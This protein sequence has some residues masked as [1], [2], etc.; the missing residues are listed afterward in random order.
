MEGSISSTHQIHTTILGAAG[1]AQPA[2][3]AA[4][5]ISNLLGSAPSS[6]GRAPPVPHRG[7]YVKQVP[8]PLRAPG[9]APVTK[10]PDVP[11]GEQGRE[12]RT[13]RARAESRGGG[14]T[15]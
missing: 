7:W 11:G 1:L 15:S 2:A 3:H 13:R 12:G 6:V 14:G 8:R 9:P 4:H 10:K 5:A